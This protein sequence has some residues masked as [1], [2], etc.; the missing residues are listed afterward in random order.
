MDVQYQ[1]CTY[2]NGATLLSLVLICRRPTWD[3]IAAG[4]ARDNCGI[5]EHLS[6]TPILSQALTTDLPEKLSRVQLRRHAGDQCLRQIMCRRLMFTYA[7]ALSQAVPAATSQVGRQHHMRT[8]LYFQGMGFEIDGL[9][10]L[11]R[12]GVALVLPSL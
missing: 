5:C 11:L 4:T 2:G 8:R 1:G 12:Y 3:H 9:P 7:A 10:N 6:P